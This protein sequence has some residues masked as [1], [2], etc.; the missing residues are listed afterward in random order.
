MR[1]AV[2]YDFERDGNL[3]LDLLGGDA[4]PLSDN[5]DVVIG[6]IRVGFDREVME[7]NR[8]G[9]E[10]QEGRREN[11]KTVVE[12]EVDEPADHLN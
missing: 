11:Q 9:N 6:D 1:D 7:G 8:A 3:L 12:C 4:G 10:Q 5:L 2:H